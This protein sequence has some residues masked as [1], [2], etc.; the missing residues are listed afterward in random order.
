M[1]CVAA[2]RGVRD[3]PTWGVPL[4]DGGTV[5]LPAHR[6]LPRGDLIPHRA[7][8]EAA[9]RLA[10][11]SRRLTEPGGARRALR[12][13]T[14]RRVPQFCLRRTA[15]AASNGVTHRD[16][17]ALEFALGVQV[18]ESQEARAGAARFAAGAGRHGSYDDGTAAADSSS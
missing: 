9:T 5:R 6:P 3:L 18:I 14:N 10:W 11:A 12:S 8:R 17:L 15:A 13:P 1:T 16:A 4:I 2:R 7:W